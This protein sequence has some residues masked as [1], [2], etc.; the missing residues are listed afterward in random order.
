MTGYGR[1]QGGGGSGEAAAA[2][3][4][5]PHRLPFRSGDECVGDRMIPP[6]HMTY[7]GAALIQAAVTLRRDRRGP[8]GRQPRGWYGYESG[9][10]RIKTPG[11]VLVYE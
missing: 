3:N 1:E 5:D 7:D 9:T 10:R 11:W 6:G 2:R 8:G 4:E